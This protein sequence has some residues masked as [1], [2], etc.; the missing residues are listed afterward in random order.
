VL[1]FQ[2]S[3]FPQAE[4]QKTAAAGSVVGSYDLWIDEVTL[5]HGD[6]GL[7][8]PPTSPGVTARNPFPHDG[9]YPGCTKPPAAAGKFIVSAYNK[10]K[11]K[12]VTTSGSSAQVNRPENGDVV[13]EG[14][15]YG[16]LIAVYMN[17]KAL[18]DGLWTYW[19]NNAAVRSASGQ[20]G[21]MTWRIGGLGGSGSALDA[22]EDAAFALLMASRQWGGTYTAALATDLIGLVYTSDIDAATGTPKGGNQYIAGNG[23]PTNPSYFAPA[24]YRVFA[25]AGVDPAHNWNAVATRVYQ[26]LGGSIV[27]ANGLTPAWC[28]FP[29][30]TQPATNVGSANVNTD[31]IFQYDAHRVPWRI[32]VDYCWN[33][34]TVVPMAG[35]TYL[36][37]ATGFFGGK[38][39]V[40]LIAD[41]YMLDAAGT[42]AMPGAG[43]NSMSVV[44]TAGVG[45]MA[46]GTNAAFVQSSY[47]LVLDGVNRALMDVSA[48]TGA[49]SGYSYYNA[50]VGLLTLL[51]MTGNF[52]LM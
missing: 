25:G 1:G 19:M 48:V 38:L 4:L 7:P 36:D 2:F 27:N 10:W 20:T 3:I 37:R 12:F 41:M 31:M 43:Y 44:G 16:M 5:I 22:D 17:D 45:G 42:A 49:Q 50:T 47:Q 52:Y 13:S 15:A 30:C 40:S 26:I 33:G 39:G 28:N 11:S 9:T 32:G 8:P 6:A 35:K 21:L 14:I 24:Y 51:T 29:A 34:G 23:D 18:F 46:S